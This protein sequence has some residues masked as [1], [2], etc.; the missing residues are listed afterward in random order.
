ME[1][2]TLGETNMANKSNEVDKLDNT[3]YVGQIK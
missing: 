1:I 2:D 3:E